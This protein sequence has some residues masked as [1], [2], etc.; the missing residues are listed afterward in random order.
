[1]F[2]FFLVQVVRTIILWMQ[3]SN[4]TYFFNEL[5][6]SKHNYIHICRWVFIWAT[7]FLFLNVNNGQ[8]LFDT[9][10]SSTKTSIK[11]NQ[12]E[13]ILFTWALHN[14]SLLGSVTLIWGVSKD[15]RRVCS[16]PVV[17]S[18]SLYCKHCKNTDLIEMQRTR[19]NKHDIRVIFC[20]FHF[21]WGGVYLGESICPPGLSEHASKQN[22]K[23]GY[24]NHLFMWI[25]L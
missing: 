4:W 13:Q 14:L 6:Y 9:E 5:A 11:T 20:W 17:T 8:L 18:Y 3:I 22:A 12:K 2:I 19:V 10:Q 7:W 21:C 23:Y 16:D 25:F 1:M 15:W 24:K